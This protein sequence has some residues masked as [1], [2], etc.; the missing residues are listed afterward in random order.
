MSL[1]T[2]HSTR[3]CPTWAA[4]V[5]VNAANPP[6]PSSIAPPVMSSVVV[7]RVVAVV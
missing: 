2:H 5:R 1:T 4:G 6:P 3:A 7:A